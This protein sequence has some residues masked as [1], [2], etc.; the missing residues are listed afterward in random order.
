MAASKNVVSEWLRVIG[1]PQYSDSF[2]ENG[3]DELEICKQIGEVDLDAIGVENM[4][5]RNKIIRSV[6]NL[7]EKGAAI[8]YVMINDPKAL[9]RSNEILS[10]C[11]IETTPKKL[12]YVMKKHLEA[13]GIRLTAHPYSTPEG[14]RGYLEGLAAH[15]SRHISMPYENVLEAIEKCRQSKWTERHIRA[16]AGLTTSRP[17]RDPNNSL[18]LH[19]NQ[20]PPI[21]TPGKYLPSSCLSNREENEIYS[22]TS[23]DMACRIPRSVIESKSTL[24]LSSRQ[25]KRSKSRFYKK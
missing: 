21:Y 9:T 12:E 14:N 11:D 1:L 4:T 19:S 5:H 3:Y 18:S 15:Y 20:N 6:R 16:T 10:E 22:F 17:F 8:V 25:A 23:Q 24:N 13:D 7:R 2:M